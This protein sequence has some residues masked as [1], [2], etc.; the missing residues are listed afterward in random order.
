MSKFQMQLGRKLTKGFTHHAVCQRRVVIRFE[1]VQHP[2]R[3][4]V[5]AN[6]HLHV[7]DDITSVSDS[8]SKT[9]EEPGD[10]A[11][12]TGCASNYKCDPLAG[13]T[14]PAGRRRTDLLPPVSPHLIKEMMEY[15]QP[16]TM[17]LSLHRS[18][19]F[20]GFMQFGCLS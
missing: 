15:F 5:D 17:T 9:P 10:P 6:K 14:P 20:S 8:L 12:S 3:S 4:K 1:T 18:V 16:E 11:P 2:H 19:L 13:C 7:H